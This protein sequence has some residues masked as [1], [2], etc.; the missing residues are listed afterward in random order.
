MNLSEDTK[1]E[2]IPDYS[3]K[4][5]TEYVRKCVQCEAEFVQPITET[6]MC[7]C[8]NCRK[9]KEEPQPE[10]TLPIQVLPSLPSV[11]EVLENLQK[12]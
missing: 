11:A 12:E 9:E 4:Q 8:W 7:L 5:P 10:E 3:P 6:L 2:E 1:V